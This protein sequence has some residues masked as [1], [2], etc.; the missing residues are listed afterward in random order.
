MKKIFV[1]IFLSISISGFANIFNH[2]TSLL[3]VRISSGALPQ[4]E[5]KL[6]DIFRKVDYE[7]LKVYLETENAQEIEK[8]YKGIAF[9]MAEYITIKTGEKFDNYINELPEVVIIYGIYYFLKEKGINDFP[10]DLPNKSMFALDNGAGCFFSLV[11]A[12][13]GITDAKSIWQSIVKG[14]AIPTI[15]GT[16]KTMFKRVATIF[17]VVVTIYGVGECL[18]W[19]QLA[20]VNYDPNIMDP[21]KFPRLTKEDLGDPT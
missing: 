15:L 20:P 11:S 16:L 3:A 13:I 9:E 14:E 8:I 18:G 12:L 7:K 10:E 19:W 1:F 17:T 2:G 6:T 5:D 4:T 21:K